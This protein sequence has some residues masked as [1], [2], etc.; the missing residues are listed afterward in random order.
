MSDGD[1]M[2]LGCYHHS[3]DTMMLALSS[4]RTHLCFIVVGKTVV[5]HLYN[6]CVCMFVCRTS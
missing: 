2:C 1:P 4:R 6:I 3:S 5:W